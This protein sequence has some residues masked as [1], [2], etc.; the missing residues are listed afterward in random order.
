M[1][2]IELSCQNEIGIAVYMM[3]KLFNSYC[4]GVI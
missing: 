2:S 3:S 4:K 1:E